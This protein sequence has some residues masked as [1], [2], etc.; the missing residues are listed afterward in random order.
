M[1][2]F[3]Q[4]DGESLTNI[5]GYTKELFSEKSPFQE[6]RVL[7]TPTFG[8]AL[9]IDDFIMIT[10]KDEFVYHEMISHVPVSLH[11]N[12]KRVVVIGGGDGGTVREL[13]KHDQIEE[14]ILC[15]IDEVVVEAS[16][17]FFPEV[18]AGLADPRVKVKIGDGIAYMKTLTNEVDIVIVDSTDP[19]GP[20][21]GLFTGAFYQS[22]RTA[23]RADGIL[24]A[25]SESPW[26]EANVLKRIYQNIQSGFSQIHPY[27]APIPTY[28]RGYWSWTLACNYPDALSG[29]KPEK[30]KKIAGD[31]QFLR[32]ENLRSYFELPAFYS[33]KLAIH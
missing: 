17:K 20:G 8:R 2:W 29:L 27:T 30:I 33:K 25:Q 1:D 16:K 11:P 31:L 22:V 28:Q 24:V 32:A 5:Y 21:E 15:E 4:K 9:I 18:A 26:F 7:E 12:P 23:L 19:I 10:E 13:L 14:I 6:V 3:Y